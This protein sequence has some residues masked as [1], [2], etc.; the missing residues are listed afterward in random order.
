MAAVMLEG[1]A[2]VESVRATEVPGVV[3]GWLVVDN[4]R[5]AKSQER[6]GIVVCHRPCYLV[7]YFSNYC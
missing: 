3:G 1:D 5:A 6:G 2:D 4:D 7:G